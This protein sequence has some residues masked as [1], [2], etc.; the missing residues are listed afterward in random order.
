[1]V[2]HIYCVNSL[3]IKDDSG[4][5]NKCNLQYRFV[6]KKNVLGISDSIKNHPGFSDTICHQPWAR[7]RLKNANLGMP[8]LLIAALEDNSTKTRE[9]L[10]VRYYIRK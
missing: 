2:S 4:I 1:M 5:A 6:K 9:L 10:F 8:L 7:Q 3:T